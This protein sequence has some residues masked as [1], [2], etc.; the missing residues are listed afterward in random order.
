M[1]LPMLQRAGPVAE[2]E[3]E[4][5]GDVQPSVGDGRPRVRGGRQPRPCRAARRA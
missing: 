1:R 4:V 2:V 3:V 5:A